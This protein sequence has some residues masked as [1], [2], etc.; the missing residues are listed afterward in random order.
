MIPYDEKWK[1]IN[2]STYLFR[3]DGGI[4]HHEDKWKVINQSTYLF[5]EC[6][7]FEDKW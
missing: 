1:F 6:G 2:Q 3:G 5:R 7:G 4:D